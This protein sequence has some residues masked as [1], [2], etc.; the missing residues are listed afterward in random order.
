MEFNFTFRNVE[1]MEQ[2][3][4]VLDTAEIRPITVN[5]RQ[6]DPYVAIWNTSKD[7]L[8][9]VVLKKDSYLIQH[10]DA[11]K[12]FVKAIKE[13]GLNVFG[14]VKNYGGEVIVEALFDDLYV[15]DDAGSKIHLGVRLTNT[16]NDR[17]PMFK[18]EAFGFRHACNN[19]M[20]LG[21]VMMSRFYGKHIKLSDLQK[22]LLE[23]ITQVFN[24][25]KFLTDNIEKAKKE[26]IPS[27]KDAREIFYGEFY[28]K[29]LA[30]KFMEFVELEN[31]TRYTLYNAVTEY[32][33]KK[34][35]DERQRELLQAGAQRILVTPVRLLRR[36][37]WEE[38]KKNVA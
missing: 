27:E 17:Y 35:R 12:P 2:Q 18:G 21:Q 10:K 24:N 38:K 20:A 32:A 25:A 36:S 9:M 6:I 14:N 1:E 5:G 8:E 33:T 31:M 29:R 15:E 28:S 7:I 23:F 34:A 30:E 26:I 16:Y 13:K 19:G 22:R 37:A 3:I 11:F 4:Q